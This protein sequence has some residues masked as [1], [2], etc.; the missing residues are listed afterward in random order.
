MYKRIL[1]IAFTIFS[2]GCTLAQQSFGVASKSISSVSTETGKLY[3]GNRNEPPRAIE[4]KEGTITSSSFLANINEYFGIPAE[5]TFTEIET[6]IDNLGMRHRLLQ[7]NYEGIPLEGM[8][9]RVHEKNGFVTSANGKSVRSISIDPRTTLSEQQAFQLAKQ[10]LQTK[11]TTVQQGKKLIVSKNFTFTPESF[12]IAFQFD[13]DVSLIERWRVSIDASNGQLINKVS[14]VNSCSGEKESPPLPY[15]TATGRTHYYGNQTIRV[16]QFDVGS[17]RLVG[18]TEH[19]GIVGTYDFQNVS[20]ISMLLFWEYHKVYDYYSGDNN[21]SDP[22]YRTAVSAQ[23]GAE[24]TFEYYF[25]KHGRNSFDNLGSA[26]KSYT[27]IGG[28]L[29]NAMWNGRVMAFGEGSNNNPLVELDV[30][31]HEFTHAVTQYEARLQYY[32]E[33]GAINESF[34][35]IFGKA[36]EFDKFGDTATWQ[37]AKYYRD[38]GLRD[39]SNP[40][41]KNQPDTY[42]GDMWY[43]GYEDNGGVHYNSGVQNFWYYLLCKG[44]TGVND[45][46]SN[47]SIK[48]I[49]M[50]AATK[51]AYRNLTEYL[52]YASDYLDSRIGSLLATA[53]LY[54]KNSTTYQEVA[55]AWD[56]VGVIDEPIITSL[57]LFDITATT[58]KIRGSLL[59][60][61][62]TVTYHFEYGITPNFGSSSAIKKYTGNIED[63]LTGLQSSTK[64]YLRLVATNENGSSYWPTDF[65]TISLAP[66]VKI[67]QTVDVTET[68]ATLY[69]QI[70]PNSLATSFYFEYGTTPAFGLTTAS[71]QLP[72]TTEFLNVSLPITNLLPRQ[73]YFYRLVATNGFAS[74]NSDA[75]SFFTSVKPVI[76]SFSPIAAMIGTEI[77]IAGRDFNTTKEKNRISFGATQAVVVSASA[78]QLKVKVPA[79]ASLAPIALLDTESGLFAQSSNAFV[80]TY[81]GDFKKGELQVRVGINDVRA[82]QTLVDDIDGDRRPDIV[83]RHD[84][85][86]SVYQNVNQGGDITEESFVRNTFS[87]Y[88][89]GYLS[90]ADMDGNG[91]KDVVGN[92]QY[93]L[94]IL[95]NYSVPGFV[96]FGSPIDLP[97][98]A[99]EFVLQDFD[100]DGHVD[101]A[102]ISYESGKNYFTVYR[103]ENPKGS[104]SASNFGAPYKKILLEWCSNLVAGDMDSDGLIDVTLSANNKNY[105]WILKNNSRPGGFVFEEIIKQDPTRGGATRYLP[106]DFNQDG[107]N[108]LVSNSRYSTGGKVTLHESKV[109]SPQI[110]LG[111]PLVLPGDFT[112]FD[113]KPADLNG[114]GKVDLLLG[115]RNRTF[116]FLKNK[117]GSGDPFSNSSFENFEEN[118]MSLGNTGS[119]SVDPQLT[120]NDLNGDGRPEVIAAYSYYY[121]PHDGYQMEIWQNATPNCLDPSLIK[122]TTSMNTATIV[123][124]AN[125][126]LD[127]F[128]LEYTQFGYDSWTPVPSISFY[129][130]SA[131]QY[132][133]RARAQ[134][135][136]GFTNYYYLDFSSDCVDTNS[137][138]INNISATSVTIQAT[139]LSSFEVQYSMAGTNQWT[140]LPQTANQISGL[141]PGTTYDLRFRGRCYTTVQF[142]N[143]QFTTLCPKLNTLTVTGIVYNK[144]V[145][146][147]TS[148]YPGNAILEYS[149]DNM[150]WTLIPDSREMFPLLP[151]KQYFVRGRKSCTNVNSDFTYTSFTTPCPKISSLTVDAIT[152]FSARINWRDDTHTGDYTL[153]YSLTANGTVTTMQTRSTSI[154]LNGLKPGAKYTVNVAPQCISTKDF[155]T[156]TFSTVCFTPFN[157]SVSNI[158]H[159]K[160]ELSWNDT[161][162]GVPYF[163][164]FSILGSN[165]WQTAETSA[166]TLPLAGLRPASKYEARVHINCLSEVAPYTSQ[167]FETSVYQ[168]TTLAPNPTDKSITIYPSK[169]LIGS[170]FGIYD[171]AGKQVAY[172]DLLEYTIDLSLVPTGIFTLKIDGEKTMKIVKY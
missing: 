57:E 47:Y 152:P 77:I 101:I 80:P 89:S 3:Y 25:K 64:Y 165:V 150:N 16:E 72:D 115:N 110:S 149:V 88:L 125:T 97:I 164:D 93:G 124:P 18:Q 166:T 29:D 118:G 27:R 95:P 5:Y 79:G 170:R 20:V 51:I 104:L 78:T 81:S 92:Y 83:A 157:L 36:V 103:N 99:S 42:F 144:A 102:N 130:Y 32:N 69:G 71:A 54:G 131:T 68:S 67:K 44:G 52:G 75:T 50:Q 106:Q 10:Y 94:R 109:I 145:V 11:D 158:T 107:R 33:S 14:L 23:W 21:Y 139:N 128:Q 38:G 82:F 169:N 84:P 114:D 159:T 70:N 65:T 162:G 85:G 62:D 26:I 132:K 86:F 151:A 15:G 2:T 48:P 53:D 22:F 56:A 113:V 140:T 112:S 117:M 4:F 105:F 172:G 147:W 7:Q 116:V 45:Q 39:M 135:Y 126:K 61:G 108:D 137:F 59:P 155:T 35:D 90:L 34:S 129:I 148:T 60:R 122:V 161:F 24:Q 154:A 133:L 1:I 8:V 40:N 43:K 141:S 63:V 171:N 9:Y 153:T 87:G 73:N 58:V 127:Q 98:G 76:T 160:A 100:Q 136:L 37:V 168:E 13:I 6:N 96:F 111:I 28:F 143:R 46:G 119:Y 17:S 134:C 55:N 138:S 146:G 120:V 41:L 31:A 156:S 163:I 12:S 123:L 142:N 167:F 49:G 74:T 30:V 121:G 19:G 91:L 66:L